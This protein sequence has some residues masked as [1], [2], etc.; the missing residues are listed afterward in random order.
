[1]ETTPYTGVPAAPAYPAP[2]GYPAPEYAAPEYPAPAYPAPTSDTAVPDYAPPAPVEASAPTTYPGSHSAPEAPEAPAYD[3]PAGYPAA[4]AHSATPAA[5]LPRAR[6]R[7][8][9]RERARPRR[10]GVPRGVRAPWS[11]TAVPAPSSPSARATSRSIDALTIDARAGRLRPAHH[12]RCPADDPHQRRSLV[13]LDDFPV[14][15]PPVIQRVMYAIITQ[16]QREKFEEELELDFAYSLPG[17]CPLPREHVPAARLRRCG[18]PHHPV[19]DQVAREPRRPAVGGELRRPA[20]RLRA[21]DG[22]DRLGQVHDPRSAGRPGEPHAARPHHDRR[23]PDRVPAPA[24]ELPGQPARGGGG[25]LVVRQR[26]Q[27]RAAPGPR[28]HPGRRDA[29]PRDDLGRPDRRR[30][31]SPR[32]RDAAH[33]GRRAD[34][35]PHHRRLPAAPAAAGALPA[36]DGPAGRRLPDPVPRPRTVTAASS[37]RRCSS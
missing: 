15:T 20:A 4:P 32:V 2:T 9:G 6:A 24:Q 25:H 28:H 14:L 7:A 19:R 29:R 22:S 36:R 13:A 11:A 8:R 10:A 3:P 27:A 12:D 26:A 17:P 23:G 16:A 34:D 18:L 30:D 1:M 35:R 21:G 37:P 33:A 5:F 31:R